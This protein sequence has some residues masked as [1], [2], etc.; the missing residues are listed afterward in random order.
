MENRWFLICLKFNPDSLQSRKYFAHISN[1]FYLQ[2]L[3][4]YELKEF[5]SI[6]SQ[7]NKDLESRSLTYFF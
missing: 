6:L 4:L 3:T 7:N 1:L 2:R 5:G